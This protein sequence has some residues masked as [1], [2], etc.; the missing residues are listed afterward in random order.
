MRLCA[1]PDHIAIEN[2]L[3]DR[4]LETIYG[5][6]IGRFLI[7]PL[8]QPACSQLAGRL[9]DS[10]IS[11]ALVH[12][13]VLNNH[14]S[15]KEC[16][17]QNFHS[18]ND[19]FTRRLKPDARRL[20]PNPEDLVSPCDARLMIYPVTADGRF[21]IKHTS[22]TLSELLKDSRLAQRFEGGTL[23]LFRLSVD[24]Y[25]RYI[26]VDDGI[27]SSERKIPGVL[28]TVN[29]AANDH[30]PIYKENCREYT[31]QKSRHFGTFIQME[32]GAMMVGK[33]KNANGSESRISVKRG[34]EKGFFAFGGSTILLITQRGTV[35]PDPRI[36]SY[37]IRGIETRVLQGETIGTSGK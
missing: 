17:K 37:S 30:I 19:F 24:D 10:P 32:V 15:L 3:Q 7:R 20:S 22:Y 36:L 8:I 11:S 18:Y 26:Y 27:R 29:P 31:L 14:I 4:F 6:A 25:H 33:I 9:L 2:N 1:Y 5:H 34:E 28:H 35:I 12:P 16:E 23:F 21:Q 13:F